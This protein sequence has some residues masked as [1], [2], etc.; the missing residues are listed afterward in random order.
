[1]QIYGYQRTGFTGTLLRVQVATTT[2]SFTIHGISEAKASRLKQELRAYYQGPLPRL[3]IQVPPHAFIDN[4]IAPVLLAMLCIEKNLMALSSHSILLY[5]TIDL[6]GTLTSP[7]P[8]EKELTQLC[9]EAGIALILSGENIS[10]IHEY[11]IPCPSIA[12]ALSQLWRFALRHPGHEAPSRMAS[13]EHTLKGDPFSGILGLYEAKQAL[14]YAVA[15]ELPLLFYGP[16]G[17]GK[18]LLLNRTK[19]LLPPLKGERAQ[20]VW[21]IH[22]RKKIESPLLRLETGMSQQ[23]LLSGNPP[24]ASLAHGGALLVDELSDQ[25]PKVR[26]ALSQ[27]LDTCKIGDYPLQCTLVAAMNGCRCANLGNP[28]GIC[29]CTNAQIDQF[30]G[31]VGW[32]LLDRFAIAIALEPEPLLAGSVQAFHVDMEAM[33]HVRSLQ[34]VRKQEG[35]AH[36]FPRYSKVMAHTQRSLRRAKLCCTLAQVIADWEGKEE[37]TLEIM[38]QAYS[39]YLLPKDRHYH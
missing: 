10:P 33:E 27:L 24:W 1:M 9:T 18:S 28:N 6:S 5:G 13:K 29:R 32:P 16:P 38:E 25:K 34:S 7:P 11:C 19:Q 23:R 2:S 20:E 30:W 17:S 21:A 35:I 36:L 15:G 12:S 26:T 8:L 3:S 4:I 37:V 14:C 22:G 31:Q 39:L